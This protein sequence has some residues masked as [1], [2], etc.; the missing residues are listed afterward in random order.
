L[1]VARGLFGSAALEGASA[2]R[3]PAIRKIEIGPAGLSP[4]L[5]EAARRWGNV[6][7]Q[8]NETIDRELRL[9]I[10]A[11]A[12][13]YDIPLVDENDKG[14]DGPLTAEELARLPELCREI[15]A[16]HHAEIALFRVK[17][18]SRRSVRAFCASVRKFAGKNLT[19]KNLL[20]GAALYVLFGI[21]FGFG[22]PFDLGTG[23][24]DW[25]R[26]NPDIVRQLARLVAILLFFG[27]VFTSVVSRLMEMDE[28]ARRAAF[29][30]PNRNQEIQ[31]F[32]EN[33]P[34]G[35]ASLAEKEKIMRAL[36]APDDN[37]TPKFEE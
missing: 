30:P 6:N 13:A 11:H 33:N 26:E 5:L 12:E 16:G 22:T 36:L 35:D 23:A 20:L 9:N 19:P 10:R 34:F 15:R 21:G 24:I 17:Y 25:A 1:S 37:S 4:A 29:H 28:R 7:I 2:V 14:P 8:R 18:G 3:N 31:N 27:V 32:R